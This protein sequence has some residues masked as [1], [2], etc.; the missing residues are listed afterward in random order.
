MTVFW[1]VDQWY[2][3]GCTHPRE[4]DADHPTAHL[5]TDSAELVLGWVKKA[6]EQWG[7]SVEEKGT[8]GS[9]GPAG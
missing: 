2:G 4:E 9:F 7:V 1:S 3:T 8:S 6:E 5:T